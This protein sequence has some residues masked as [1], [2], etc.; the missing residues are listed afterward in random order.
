MG[1]MVERIKSG[2]Y[3][4]LLMFLSFWSAVILVSVLA[5]VAIYSDRPVLANVNNFRITNYAIDYRLSVDSEGRSVL[6]TTEKVEA[7]FLVRNQNRG[8]IRELPHAYDEHSTSLKIESVTDESGRA[9]EYQTD[10]VSDMTAI[11]I[12]NPDEY[13][14]GSKTYIIKYSQR[15]VTK[16]FAS[17]TGRDEFYWDTNGTGWLVG[18]DNLDV[19]LRVDDGLARQ[20]TGDA[21]CYFGAEGGLGTC[22]IGGDNGEGL[23][24][25]SASGLAP[26]ENLTLA[27]GFKDG[28]FSEYQPTMFEKYLGYALMLWIPGAV[29]G[30]VSI[31]YGSVRWYKRH[32]RSSEVGTVVNEFLAPRDMSV[33]AS[34][35]LYGRM[36][37]QYTA[38]LLDLAVRGYIQIIETRPKS[39]FKQAK[40]DIE[41]KKDTS[42]LRKEEL[43]VLEDLFNKSSL[44]VGSKVSLQEVSK[45]SWYASKRLDD[46]KNIKKQHDKVYKLRGKD[47]VASSRFVRIGAIMMVVGIPLLNPFLFGAGLMVLVLGFSLKPLTDKGLASTRYLKGLERY[48]KVAEADRIKY[49]QSP[50]GVSRVPRGYDLKSEASVLKLNEK[51][52]PYAVLFGI[53]KQWI[54]ELAVH[55]QTT[56]SNPN[57]YSGSSGYLTA[58]AL[59][60]SLQSFTAGATMANSS[61]SPTGGSSGGG[62]SGGGGGGGGGG[63]W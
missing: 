42:D 14:Y 26:G 28:T 40:H 61:S 55:Y 54:K 7:S 1:E 3:Q 53:E 27:V 48:M 4:R 2:R 34:A 45:T 10:R 36:V 24:T 30:L 15:D 9:L 21:N 41:I 63:G 44:A 31:L 50:K 11:R 32:N 60:S 38:Q 58:A 29:I 25:A 56:D 57:W 18:I 46:A 43:E 16:S 8:I 47:R 13:V 49:L 23:F 12:G 39:T 6:D 37:Q 20:L 59:S 35:M 52:L 22:L 62:Y 33:S 19:S 5:S 51:L 17:S